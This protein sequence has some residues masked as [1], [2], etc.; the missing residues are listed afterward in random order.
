MFLYKNKLYQ[1]IDGVAMGSPLGPTLANFFLATVE[2]KLLTQNL[3]CS[4]KL[5]LRYVDDIFAIF[6][7][8][9]SSSKFLEVLNH[10]NKN[11]EF[12]MEKSIGAFPFLDVQ[13]NNNENILETRI[14][15][16]PTHTGVLLN[17]SVA[18]PEQWKTGLIIC[19]LKRANTICSTDN[20]FWT[21]VKNLRYMATQIGFLINVSKS[22]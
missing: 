17:F 10:Q 14:W 19:L 16:K 4:P 9:K 5:Y 12:T 3:D 15:R 22:F 6:E 18:C 21:E 20:I 8:E 7:E 1:L 13:I 11:L 2:T